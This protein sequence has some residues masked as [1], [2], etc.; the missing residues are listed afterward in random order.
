MIKKNQQIIMLG[1]EF[2]VVISFSKLKC[3]K[4]ENH[5]KSSSI[6]TVI[7]SKNSINQRL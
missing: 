2:I 4:H 7:I 3:S 6:K 5:I 1:Y